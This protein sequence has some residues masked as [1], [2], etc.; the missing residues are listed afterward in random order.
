MSLVGRPLATILRHA[1]LCSVGMF[2]FMSFA[3]LSFVLTSLLVKFVFSVPH[4]SECTRYFSFL[5]GSLRHWEIQGDFCCWVAQL[6][7]MRCDPL[8]CGLHNVD[9]LRKPHFK[10][11][12]RKK[13]R[14]PHQGHVTLGKY[15]VGGKGNFPSDP[16]QPP[17]TLHLLG[18]SVQHSWF[19]ASADRLEAHSWISGC[20][21]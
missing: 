11:K 5:N 1:L 16:P 9:W 4:G 20:V 2:A 8:D 12:E 13:E 6:C 3:F 18:W 19:W 14:K 7:L 10:K 17:W 15:K 21:V